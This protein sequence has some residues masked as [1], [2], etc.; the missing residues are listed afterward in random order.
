MN[1]YGKSHGGSVATYVDGELVGIA[2][3]GEKCRGL[4]LVDDITYDFNNLDIDSHT[5]LVVGGNMDSQSGTNGF[6]GL[7]CK[8]CMFNY[9]LNDRDI[10]NNYNEG[11]IDGF[12]AK[13]G[14]GAYG[15]IHI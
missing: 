1:D 12:M 5:N 8:F 7:L 15:V 3:Q 13:L 9:D 2:N 6:Q 10:Y 4:G 11:P 14:L